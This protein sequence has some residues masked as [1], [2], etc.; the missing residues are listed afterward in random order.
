MNIADFKELDMEAYSAEDLLKWAIDAF[1]PDL[2]LACSFEDIVL[3]HMMH[4][5]R[6]DIRVFAIDTGRL[7][8]ETYECAEAIRERFGVKIEWDEQPTSAVQEE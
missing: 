5:I 4:R 1:H 3:V 6:P 2:A 8:E 7:N